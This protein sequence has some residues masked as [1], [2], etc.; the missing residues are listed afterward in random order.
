M[1]LTD[2]NGELGAGAVEEKLNAGALDHRF[3]NRLQQRSVDAM[4]DLVAD[5]KVRDCLQ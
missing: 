3:G 4:Q 2:V 5:G 1:N